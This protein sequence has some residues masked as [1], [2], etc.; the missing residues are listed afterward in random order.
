MGPLSEVLIDKG[1]EVGL[2]EGR[3]EGLSELAQALQRLKMGETP[4]QLLQSGVKK[5][6]VDLAVACR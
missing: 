3:T 6:V 4:E 5:D 2:R 1:R